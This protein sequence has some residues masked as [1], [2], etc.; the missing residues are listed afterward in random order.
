MEGQGNT[1]GP[2]LHLFSPIIERSGG[3]LGVK[4]GCGGMQT[5]NDA[6]H[7]PHEGVPMLLHSPNSPVTADPVPTSVT[8]LDKVNIL[9]TYFQ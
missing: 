1:Q 7:D 9:E 2:V 5:S 4:W 8:R 3:Q 6:R